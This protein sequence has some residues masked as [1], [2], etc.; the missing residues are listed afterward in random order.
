MR[1]ARCQSCATSSVARRFRE[2]VPQ[3]LAVAGRRERYTQ[4][5]LD[6]AAARRERIE[7]LV[8]RDSAV[9]RAVD[10]RGRAAPV[11][12]SMTPIIRQGNWVVGP[13]RESSRAADR[14]PPMS[15]TWNTGSGDR[16]METERYRNAR[17]LRRLLP[18]LA[19]VR[20]NDQQAQ[21]LGP[22]DIAT[23]GAKSSGIR[24]AM[25]GPGRTGL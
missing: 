21:R 23:A 13:I 17:K 20:G 9:P 1:P 19:V 16:S 22:C 12:P 6:V 18:M 5:H 24:T 8:D 15:R 2:H 11:H 4:R 25:A 7:L 14:T 3:G 10:D